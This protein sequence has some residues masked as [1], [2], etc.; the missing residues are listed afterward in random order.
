MAKVVLFR[1]Q[2]FP[3]DDVA[4]VVAVDTIEHLITELEGDKPV[5]VLVGP[6]L[7]KELARAAI[8]IA[9]TRGAYFLRVREGDTPAW[10]KRLLRFAL[11]TT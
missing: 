6:R 9:V 2:R 7:P 5:A 4:K 8:E 1:C 10:L 3:L 11:K